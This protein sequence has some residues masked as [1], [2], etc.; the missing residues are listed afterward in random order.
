MAQYLR[1]F[2]GTLGP[3]RV[4]IIFYSFSSSQFENF[5]FLSPQ[6]MYKHN[7]HGEFQLENS[8]FHFSIKMLVDLGLKKILEQDLNQQPPD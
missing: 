1:Y 3:K 5:K 4:Y 8:F 2:E 7:K 6:K